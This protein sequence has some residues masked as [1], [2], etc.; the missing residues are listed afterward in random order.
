MKAIKI[1]VNELFVNHE[2]M[3]KL[4]KKLCDYERNL[5]NGLK[6]FENSFK[7][8]YDGKEMFIPQSNLNHK[9]ILKAAKANFS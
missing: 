6:G 4:Y 2:S 5:L 1:N 7:E 9:N 3:M 8:C